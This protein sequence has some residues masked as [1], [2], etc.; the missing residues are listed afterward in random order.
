M[1]YY[2]TILDKLCQFY[3]RKKME[4]NIGYVDLFNTGVDKIW[5]NINE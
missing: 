3:P 1:S 2:Y 4:C 5:N